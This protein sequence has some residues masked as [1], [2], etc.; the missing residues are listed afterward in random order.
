MPKKIETV[1][2]AYGIVAIIFVIL[3]WYTLRHM[4]VLRALFSTILLLSFPITLYLTKYISDTG[5]IKKIIKSTQKD[6]I[7]LLPPSQTPETEKSSPES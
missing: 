4:Y 6:S 5:G 2:I 7:A 3:L 1:W